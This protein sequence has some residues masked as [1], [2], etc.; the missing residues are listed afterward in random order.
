MRR[1][2]PRRWIL[3]DTAICQLAAKQPASLAALADIEGISAR[4][5]D[6]SGEAL[7]A[8]LAEPVADPTPLVTDQRETAE[9]KQKTQQLLEVLRNRAQQEQV[10]PTLVA[11]RSDIERLVREGAAAAI[12]L[13]TGWRRELLGEELLAK[14]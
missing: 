3:D 12:P 14:L 5:I 7:L 11:T 4:R 2:R 1:N 13:L 6:R 10:A 8:L 9:Q